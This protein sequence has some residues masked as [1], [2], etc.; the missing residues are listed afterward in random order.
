MSSRA[1]RRTRLSAPTERGSSAGAV[2][3]WF[4]ETDEP[5]CVVGSERRASSVSP[6]WDAPS[7]IAVSSRN[8]VRSVEVSGASSERH[9]ALA[10]RTFSLRRASR[11]VLGVDAAEAER[12]LAASLL[13]REAIFSTSARP[14]SPT[15]RD[16]GV[17]AEDGGREGVRVELSH[18]LRAG[19]MTSADEARRDGVEQTSPRGRECARVEQAAAISSGALQRRSSKQRH[20]ARRIVLES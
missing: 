10:T 16:R 18:G 17:V 5:V 14:S 12:A 8:T 2:P 1:S 4:R 11:G 3:E 15:F 20:R 9:F 7:S 13:D 6:G 19:C